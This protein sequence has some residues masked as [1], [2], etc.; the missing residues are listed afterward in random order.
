VILNKS[1]FEQ[2]KTDFVEVKLN[3]EIPVRS[4][5]D[6]EVNIQSLGNAVLMLEKMKVTTHEIHFQN[7]KLRL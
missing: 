7:A 2:A 3:V 5:M 6:V 4:M 1:D